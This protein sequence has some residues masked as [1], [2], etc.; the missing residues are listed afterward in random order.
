M[1]KVIVGVVVGAAVVGGLLFVLNRPEPAPPTPKERLSEAAEG[2]REATQEAVEVASDAA[3]DAGEGLASST[4]EAVD[5]M[6]AEVAEAYA[7]VAERVAQ[8]SQETQEQMARFLTD[9]K[10]SGIMTEEG[11]DFAAATAAVEASDMSVD[12]KA[13]VIAVLNALRDAP[14]A[15]EKKLDALMTLLKT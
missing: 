7:D 10:A 5:E 3:E 11:I 13:N 12:A 6:K 14:G 15:V 2:I 8:T 9:W 4:K 1:N